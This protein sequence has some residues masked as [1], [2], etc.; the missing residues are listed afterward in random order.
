M[1]SVRNILLIMDVEVHQASCFV[2]Q[3]RLFRNA[4]L[5]LGAGSIDFG[6][7]TVPEK[8]IAFAVIFIFTFVE[9]ACCKNCIL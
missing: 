7:M 2:F 5:H 3:F 8:I 4:K 1:E 6:K 9:Q